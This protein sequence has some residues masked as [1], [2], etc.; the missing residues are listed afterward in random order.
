MGLHCLLKSQLPRK[1]YERPVPGDLAVLH[2]VP[3]DD[4]SEVMFQSIAELR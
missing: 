3:V 4:L 1:R 2:Q